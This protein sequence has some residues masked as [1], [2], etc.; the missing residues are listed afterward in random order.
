MTTYMLSLFSVVIC[1]FL[2]QRRVKAATQLVAGKYHTCVVFN[3][4]TVK[5]WGNNDN[6]QLGYGGKCFPKDVNAFIL[7]AK[8]LEIE[9]N[10]IIGG[11]ETNLRVRKFKDWEK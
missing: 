3:N 4:N 2:S 1:F 10:T 8:K 7:F 5:C 6:G 11:W 9:L